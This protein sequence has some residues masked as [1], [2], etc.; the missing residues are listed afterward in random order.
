M[1]TI[2]HKH[3][4]VPRHMGGSDDPSNLIELTIEEHAE[5]HRVL[6]EQYGKEED[7]IAWMAL[8]GQASKPESMKMASKLGRAKTDKIL[9]NRYGA[10]WRTIQAKYAAEFGAVKYK[11]RYQT[12]GEFKTKMDSIRLR[13][14]EVARSPESNKK[15]KNSF[16]KIKHQQG[17]NNSNFGKIWISNYELRISKPHPKIDPIPEGWVKGRKLNW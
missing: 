12:D 5:A 14:I 3:H 4:I 10:D 13:A 9:E 16:A 8:S 17:V 2:Y 7:K 15:R 11:Q 1:S 6:F